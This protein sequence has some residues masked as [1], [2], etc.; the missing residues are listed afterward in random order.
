LLLCRC[1]FRIPSLFMLAHPTVLPA[2]VPQ[3]IHAAGFQKMTYSI[4]K[5]PSL[6]SHAYFVLWAAC[7]AMRTRCSRLAVSAVAVDTSRSQVCI[8]GNSSK[9][10]VVA[11]HAVILSRAIFDSQNETVSKVPLNPRRLPNASSLPPFS[12]YTMRSIDPKM[13]TGTVRFMCRTGPD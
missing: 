13:L 8:I 6:A 5:P 4:R 2:D 10:S 9:D 7:G 11:R 3:A 1:P 12:L